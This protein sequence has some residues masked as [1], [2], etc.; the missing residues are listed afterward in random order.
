MTLDDI[1]S[2]AERCP[3]LQVFSPPARQRDTIT[4]AGE[5]N[6]RSQLKHEPDAVKDWRSRMASDDGKEVYRRRKLTEHAH[7]Q[8]EEPWVRA[9]A[10]SWDRRGASICMLRASPITCCMRRDCG[11]SPP[12]ARDGGS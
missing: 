3:D 10:G 9:D 7:C 4:P 12:D 6:R 11:A 5:R 1:V 8:D 2:L